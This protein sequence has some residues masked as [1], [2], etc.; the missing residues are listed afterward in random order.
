MNYITTIDFNLKYIL[1]NNVI[2]YNKNKVYYTFSSI[3]IEFKDI[4]K[5][6]KSI[7]DISK[8]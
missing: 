7:I 4:F 2:I 5:N 3:I 1:L 8:E 6:L